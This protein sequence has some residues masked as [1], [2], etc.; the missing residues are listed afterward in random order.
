MKKWAWILCGLPF[1]AGCYFASDIPAE[2]DSM[3]REQL[4]KKEKTLRATVRID[5]GTLEISGSEVAGNLYT[6]GLDYDK[7]SFKP[8]IQYETNPGGEEGRLS[9]SLEGIR[10]PGFRKESY[11]NSLRL[12][13]SNSIPTDLKAYTGVGNAR[14]SL[15]GMKLFRLDFESGVGGAKVSVFEPNAVSCDY[16]NLKNGV[17]SIEA[18]GLGNLNFREFGFDGGVGGADLDFT[19]DWKQD[20]TVRIQVGV[21]GVHLKLPRSIG[22]RVETAKHFLSGM[23]LD[24]FTQRDSE[25]FSENY[26]SAAVKIFMHVTTGIGG[27]KIT[28]I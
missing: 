18:V 16:I 10:E 21:G 14:L 28:W 2:M 23:H 12:K 22:V 11:G 1:F 27:F 20:A 15:T 9:L 13:L 25:Y 5:V 3:S 19:G 6:L 24:G 17:G 4:L 8:D 7:S 26:D